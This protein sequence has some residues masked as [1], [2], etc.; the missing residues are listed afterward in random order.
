AAPATRSVEGI[1]KG[2]VVGRVDGRKVTLEDQNVASKEIAAI[3]AILPGV[4]PIEERDAT[5]WLLLSREAEA[6]GY[7]G[8]TGDGEEFLPVLGRSMAYG[9]I[10]RNYALMNEFGRDPKALEQFVESVQQ[11]IIGAFRGS[12]M[13][14]DEMYKALAR[15]R[16]VDRMLSAYRSVPRPSD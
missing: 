11:R 2:R 7:V 3:D 1:R 14:D 13:R 9:A 8:E 10:Q 4:F 12:Q 15:V 16:G 5:H 6:A